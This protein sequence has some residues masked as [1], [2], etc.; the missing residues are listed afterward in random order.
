MSNKSKNPKEIKLK[1]NEGIDALNDNG[2]KIIQ[3]RNWFSYG[4]DAV[5]LAN[6]IDTKKGQ[7]L[8]DLGTGT[9]IIPLILS[10]KTSLKSIIGIEI[11]DELAEMATR[12]IALNSLQDKITII[13]QDFRDLSNFKPASYDIVCSNPPYFKKNAAI[14]NKTEQK[15]ISRHEITMN[16]SEL[17]KS[18]FYLLKNGAYF[19]MIHRPER[20]V[21]IFEVSRAEKLEPKNIRFIKSNINSP[22]KLVLIKFAKNA[23]RE[24][25]FVDDLIIYNDDGSYTDEIREIYSKN[26]ITSF[27]KS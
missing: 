17:F 20:L 10:S 25:K 21:D 9:G 14:L 8:V 3:N 11:Q 18:A 6:S 22:A 26:H 13:N 19:Y 24:L 16:L 2:L 1:E 5:V 15:I 12:S 4:V 7:E 23:G 27:S